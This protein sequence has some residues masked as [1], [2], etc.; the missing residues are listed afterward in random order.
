MI[1]DTTFEE[2]APLPQCYLVAIITA[3]FAVFY[4]LLAD[5]PVSLPEYQLP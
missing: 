4:F 3:A 5:G 2:G 1:I